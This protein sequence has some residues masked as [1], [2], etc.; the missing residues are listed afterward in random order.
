MASSMGRE[1]RLS[2]SL[3]PTPAYSVSM[4]TVG[5]ERSGRRSTWRRE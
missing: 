2:I 1:T 3:G 5:K 4:E